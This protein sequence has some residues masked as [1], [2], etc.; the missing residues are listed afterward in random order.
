[1]QK[2]KTIKVFS[3]G[4]INFTYKIVKNSSNNYLFSEKDLKNSFYNKKKHNT[5][6]IN[7]ENFL[8]YKNKYIKKYNK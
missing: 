4:S 3:N 2:F 6:L 5:I 8:N 7:K 1:M